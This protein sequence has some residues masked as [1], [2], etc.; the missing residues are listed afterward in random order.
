MYNCTGKELV[1]TNNLRIGVNI[2]KLVSNYLT[3]EEI[4]VEKLFE[5]GKGIE[6][7]T[8]LKHKVSDILD[9]KKIRKT[10]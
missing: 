10:N 5:S 1:K 6:V 3:A 8:K 7:R 9:S 4:T 2:A